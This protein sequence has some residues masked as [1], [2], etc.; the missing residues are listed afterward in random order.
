V[1]GGVFGPGCDGELTRAE[2]DERLAEVASGGGLA[3]T[4]GLTH[5]VVA[6]LERAVA[7]VPTEASALPI[8][9]FRGEN[10]PTEIRSG[11]RTVDLTEDVAL[12]TYFDVQAAI[13]SAAR[14]AAAVRD[15]TSLE[16]AND[17]LHGL[18][19]RTELDLE[20]AAR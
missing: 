18:G 2:V 10:G 19:V 13:G 3:G 1:L 16:E 8:R 20:R 6:E 11:R 7:A 4:V 12:T 5:D 15:A 17:M 14:L 9:A